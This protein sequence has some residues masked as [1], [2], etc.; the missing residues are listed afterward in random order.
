MFSQELIFLIG[1]HGTWDFYKKIYIL[2][3]KISFRYIIINVKYVFRYYF[4][5]TVDYNKGIYK[6]YG[7][8]I[9]NKKIHHSFY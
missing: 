6:G 2:K 1:I 5:T 3:F 9:F 8:N 4:A 7:K